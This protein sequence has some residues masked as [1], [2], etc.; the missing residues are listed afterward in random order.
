MKSFQTIKSYLCPTPDRDQE[1]YDLTN[2]SLSRLAENINK[3]IDDPK[4]HAFL[5]YV[6]I[7]DHVDDGIL[8]VLA[9]GERAKEEYLKF[10]QVT[11][12]LIE[13]SF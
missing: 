8:V 11:E 9:G 1:G 3:R 4:E 6:P 12:A 2:E 10:E 5:V 13:E 7:E